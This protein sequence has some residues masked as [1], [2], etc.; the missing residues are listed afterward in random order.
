MNG[1][2][3]F[4]FMDDPRSGREKGV[5][6]IRNCKTMYRNF[7]GAP[8]KFTDA[9]RRQFSIIIDNELADI[10]KADGWNVKTYKNR[11]TSGEVALRSVAS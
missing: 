1:P 2:F 5:L 4:R 8:T 3:E 7:A 10:L 11:Q 6:E 9:G